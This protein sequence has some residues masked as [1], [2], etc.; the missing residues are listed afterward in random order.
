M[1]TADKI[2]IYS[3]ELFNHHGEASVSSVDIANELDISPGNLYYHFKGKEI[4]IKAL[5]DMYYQ[6]MSN[7]LLAPERENFDIDGFFDYLLVIFDV[8]HT[9][10]FL[11][12]NPAENFEKYPSIDKGFA[13]ILAATEKVF[14]NCLNDLVKQ[15]LL[16]AGRI[17]CEQMSEL[18]TLIATQTTNY[19]LLRGRD[20]NDGIYIKNAMLQILFSLSSYINNSNSKSESEFKNLKDRIDNLNVYKS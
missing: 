15:K 8:A 12:R 4:I 7:T 11:Y 3:L 9:F 2:L 13:R 18:I 1:K 10:R 6:Q 19:E 5:F 14:I 17:Q 16:V 20:I